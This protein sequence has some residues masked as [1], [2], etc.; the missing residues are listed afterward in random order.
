MGP[1]AMTTEPTADPAAMLRP[2]LALAV[3]HGHAMP[4]LTWVVDDFL[5]ESRCTACR[6]NAYAAVM[7]IM[8]QWEV[9]AWGVEQTC[10]GD[11]GLIQDY[12]YIDTTVTPQEVTP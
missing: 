6:G 10:G 3:A 2:L 11:R 8:G 4:E 1:E 9:D 5:L 12:Q 7:R